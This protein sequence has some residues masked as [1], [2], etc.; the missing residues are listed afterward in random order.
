V[1][2]YVKAFTNSP[3]LVCVDLAR[4]QEEVIDPKYLWIGPDGKKLKG[5]TYRNPTETGKLKVKRFKESMSGAYTCTRSYKSTDPTTQEERE[6]FE[7]YRF[8]VYAYGEADRA[9][10]IFVRFTTKECELAAHD[11]FFEELKKIVN[12]FISDLMC[13]ITESSYRCLSVQTP[14]Q[15]LQPRLFVTFQV[16]PFAPGW[17]EVCHQVPYTCEDATNTRVEEARNRI[18]EFFS[19]QTYALKHEFQT[20]PTT[21]YVDDSFSALQIESC[22]PGF[23]KNNVTHQSCAGCCVVC[24]PGTYSPNNDV[25]CQIRSRP[26]VRTYRA[27]SC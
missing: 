16:N 20:V 25:T 1:N 17:E 4:S 3:V 27:R 18:E 11:R 19:E 26:R 8:R 14:T 7:A 21:H 2:V 23:G 6:V 22:R 15:R 13:H 10:Q 5:Q 24:E 12:N 9:Y